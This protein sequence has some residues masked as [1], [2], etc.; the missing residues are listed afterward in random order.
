MIFLFCDLKIYAT[1]QIDAI[2]FGLMQFGIDDLCGH[3][4]LL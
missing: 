2:N 3:I 4:Y 1:F